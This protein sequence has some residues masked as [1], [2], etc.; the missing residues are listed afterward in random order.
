MTY[1]VDIKLYKNRLTGNAL[2]GDCVI[3]FELGIKM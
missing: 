1:K 2:A 3:V